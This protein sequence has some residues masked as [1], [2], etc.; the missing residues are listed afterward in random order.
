[1]LVGTAARRRWRRRRGRARGNCSTRRARPATATRRCRARPIPAVLRRMT[2]E[3]I[4][5]VLTTGVMQRTGHALSDPAKRAIAEYLGDRKLGA[6]ES[7]AVEQMPNRCEP[8]SAPRRGV[9]AR[10]ERLGR[11]P[12]QH[13]LPASAGRGLQAVQVP[14]LA[15]RWAFAL[16]GAT[17]VYGQPTAVDGRVFVGAD[18]GYVYALDQQTGCVHWAFQAAG[19]RPQRRHDRR[20]RGRPPRRVLRRSQGQRL[21]PGR[22]HRR[23]GLDQPR[24]RPR[25]GADHGVAGAVSRS[26]LR[27]GGVRRGRRQHQPAVSV[28]HVPRQR[29]GAAGGHRRRGVEDLHHRRRARA[30]AA[31][32]GGRPDAR[33]VRRRACGTPRP[34][35][36]VRNALYVGTGNN[37][38]RPDDAGLRRG[39]GDGPRHRQGAVDAAGAGRRRVDPGVRGRRRAGRQLSREHRARLRLRRL[40]DPED[41]RRRPAAAHH[42]GQERRG[43]GDGPRSRRRGGVEDAAAQHACRARKARWCGAARP[44]IAISTSA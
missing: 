39:D 12:R 22:R 41:D 7:G 4:Y 15:L 26:P 18:S 3:R 40:A 14:R 31:V 27:V 10:L 1:M 13:A 34:S 30:D 16:P 29:A 2:P 20:D 33:A 6:R 19:R 28:L 37:Y 36:R 38:S 5:G 21:R 17:A 44:T 23:A 35:I 42:R 32:A 43:L 8:S 9:A 24:R 11:G 25:A